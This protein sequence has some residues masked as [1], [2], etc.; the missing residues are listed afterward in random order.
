M[1]MMIKVVMMMSGDDEESGD[2]DESGDSGQWL[3]RKLS[4]YAFY[5]K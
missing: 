1:V 4:N 3:T 2:D 5:Q